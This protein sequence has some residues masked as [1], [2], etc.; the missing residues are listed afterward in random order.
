MCKPAPWNPPVLLFQS[1]S[2]LIR[3]LK[4]DLSDFLNGCRVDCGIGKCDHVN[5]GSGRSDHKRMMDERQC[6][7][8]TQIY[9]PWSQ[10]TLLCTWQPALFT[11]SWVHLVASFSSAGTQISYNSLQ[12]AFFFFPFPLNCLASPIHSLN[13]RHLSELRVLQEAWR[14]YSGAG[15][16]VSKLLTSVLTSDGCSVGFHTDAFHKEKALCYCVIPYNLIKAPL[17]C[18]AQWRRVCAACHCFH[19]FWIFGCCR[20]QPIS[21]G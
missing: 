1:N 12:E 3:S 14:K 8:Q 21:S 11:A 9:I 13:C 17:K 4:K 18:L 6:Y 19:V 2:S 15:S 7:F 16:K 5:C 20:E 10:E